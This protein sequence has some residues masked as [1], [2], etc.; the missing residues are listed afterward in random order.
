[1]EVVLPS[2]RLSR[3]RMEQ[4]DTVF[5]RYAGMDYVEICVRSDNGD[6]MRLTLPVHVNAHDM[7]LLAEVHAILGREAD[8]VL[9]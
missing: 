3:G 7:M 6:T 9:V 1:M 4:L 2:H 5:S 8:I